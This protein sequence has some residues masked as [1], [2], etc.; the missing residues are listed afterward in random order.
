MAKELGFKQGAYKEA[1]DYF[2]QKINLPTK[3]WNDIEGAMHTRAFV[4]AGA[5][6]EDIL[7]DFRKAVESAIENGDSLQDFR[8][9]FYKIASKWRE[10]DPSFDEKMKKP[11][12]GAWRSKVIYQT[13][14]LTAAAAAQ[15]RQARAMPDVFTHAKYVC[16]MLPTSREEHKQWN[17]TVLPVNDPWWEKHSPP[18]G[19]G[20][21]CEKEFISK[22]EMKAGLEKS[23]DRPTDPENTDHIGENWDYS[24]GDADMGVIYADKLTKEEKKFG[25][26]TTKGLYEFSEEKIPKD[27]PRL[28]YIDGSKYKT[29]NLDQFTNDFQSLLETELKDM[30]GF[31]KYEDGVSFNMKIGNI[32]YPMYI[33]PRF[34]GKHFLTHSETDDEWRPERTAF[35]PHFI[36]TLKNP[37]TIRYEFLKNKG[38]KQAAINVD[39]AS[40]F[41]DVEKNGKNKGAAIKLVFR[42]RNGKLQIWTAFKSS[43]VRMKMKGSKLK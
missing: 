37:Y 20:C 2:K 43:D 12:Y 42:A 13:N 11:K 26:A 21:L 32:T 39:F 38:T 7:C 15:E 34:L 16:M 36:E 29:E 30:D 40:I 18:N 35:I 6:R 1:V 17:G 23:T 10:S 9:S 8:D 33:N 19:F 41:D 3:R 25:P 5:M 4:V 27:A 31:Q 24:I 14:M 28:P 22:Y